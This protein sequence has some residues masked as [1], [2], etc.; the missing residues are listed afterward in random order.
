MNCG[1][2][3]KILLSVTQQ[4]VFDYMIDFGSITTL[5]AI[6]DLGETRLSA[7]IYELQDKG[8]SIGSEWEE[9]KNRYGEK[10]RVKRYFVM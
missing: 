8:V 10:R 6:M 9:V 7:R 1:G 3:Q 2:V 4:R 5:Q